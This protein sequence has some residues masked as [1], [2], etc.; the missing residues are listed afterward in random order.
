MDK[1]IPQGSL[2]GR[3]LKIICKRI[4]KDSLLH[5]LYLMVSLAVIKNMC[6][7]T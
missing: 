7:V 1:K 6:N 5:L 4:N 2:H 3:S